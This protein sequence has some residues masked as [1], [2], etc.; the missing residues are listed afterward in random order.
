[1]KGLNASHK[2]LF[3]NKQID[4]SISLIEGYKYTFGKIEYLGNS[5]YT[6]QQL[7]QILKIKEGDTYNGVELCIFQSHLHKLDFHQNFPQELDFSI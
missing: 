2:C 5:V 3:A 7:N 4:V 1:V 6:D